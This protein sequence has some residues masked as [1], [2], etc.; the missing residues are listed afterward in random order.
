M[1]KFIKT[2]DGSTGL[3]DYDVKDVYHSVTGAKSESIDK[4]ITGSGFDKFVKSNDTVFVADICYGTGYNSKAAINE[5]FKPRN[6]KNKCKIAIDAFELNSDLI[7]LSPFIYDGFQNPNINLIIFKNLLSCSGFFEFMASKLPE[8]INKYSEFLD[9][10]ITSIL[11]N[12]IDNSYINNH[13]DI[14]IDNLHNIYYDYIS[15]SM[16]SDL[17]VNSIN[18]VKLNFFIGNAVKTF[19]EVNTVYD[20]VFHDGF[21]PAKQPDLWTLDFLSPVKSKMHE[22]S[23]F[24]TYSNSTPVRNALLTLGFNVGKIISDGKQFGTVASMNSANVKYPLSDYDIGICNTKTGTVYRDENLSSTSEEILLRHRLD[25][26]KC[27]KISASKF[28]KIHGYDKR[29]I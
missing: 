4:F 11:R 6:S 17:K 24:V 5:I 8:T 29:K 2:D 14:S 26:E 27:D 15:K 1:Y 16:K 9:M 7:F 21:T 3:Y 22:N 10:N 23:V 28:K 12:F 25:T 18:D 19:P 13:S 20:F